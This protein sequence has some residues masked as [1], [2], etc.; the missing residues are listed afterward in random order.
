MKDS[1]LKKFP[2]L[3]RYNQI[4]WAVIG[5]GIVIGVALSFLAG[6]AALLISL[7]DFDRSGM[8]V[9]VTD[10]T[11]EGAERGDI[12]Y[13]FCQPLDVYNS[14]YQLIRVVSNKFAIKKIPSASKLEERG[15][16]T[17]LMPSTDGCGIHGS[18]L[19]TGAVNFIIRNVD[20]NSMYLFL[21]ENAVIYAMEYPRPREE[22]AAMFPPP[23]VLYWEISFKDSNGDSRIDLLDD[24]GAYLSDLD[25]LRLER[26]TPPLSRV[27]EK[28]YDAKRNILTLRIL[29][30]MNNDGVLNGEDRPSLIEV[31]VSQRIM[32]REILNSKNLI[33]L[34]HQAEPER[35]M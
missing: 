34:M 1:I 20:S 23:G 5:S 4:L 29:G 30:D 3:E 14:P 24:T 6:V 18:D 32:I 31:S 13:D 28:T 9:T 7:L 33:N 21:K 16:Y 17:D 8:E 11:S 27:L 10:D 35:E 22:V 12:L 25:G 19:P 26:I 15:L 2:D